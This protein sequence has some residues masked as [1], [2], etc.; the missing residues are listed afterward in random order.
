MNGDFNYRG[1]NE[2][3]EITD[4]VGINLKDHTF[5]KHIDMLLVKT[6]RARGRIGLMTFE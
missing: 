3:L 2:K 4:V 5:G 1:I 6:I